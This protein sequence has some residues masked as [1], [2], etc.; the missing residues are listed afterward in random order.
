MEFGRCSRD[1]RAPGRIRVVCG[2][3]NRSVWRWRAN[4]F[5]VTAT[6]KFLDRDLRT[7]VRF[8]TLVCERASTYHRVHVRPGGQINRHRCQ[9]RDHRQSHRTWPEHC[10]CFGCCTRSSCCCCYSVPVRR[11]RTWMLVCLFVRV[12]WISCVCVCVSISLQSN[13]LDTHTTMIFI[14]IGRRIHMLACSRFEWRTRCP[15]RVEWRRAA[16]IDGG[17]LLAKLDSGQRRIRPHHTEDESG[18]KIGK[19]IVWVFV[20]CL[21]KLHYYFRFINPWPESVSKRI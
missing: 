13:A 1:V 21:H 20:Y 2:K 5:I 14:A 7:C 18:N 15:N 6:I 3:S 12:F 11:Q 9:A 8:C 4:K 17:Y 10:R 19:Q 16:D